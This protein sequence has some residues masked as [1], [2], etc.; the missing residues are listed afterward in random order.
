[1][2]LT[3]RKKVL[4]QPPGFLYICTSEALFYVNMDLIFHTCVI[5][6]WF[7]S[8]SPDQKGC[9]PLPGWRTRVCFSPSLEWRGRCSNCT[10]CHNLAW[11]SCIRTQK[12]ATVY[13]LI[14]LTPCL[15]ISPPS[16]ERGIRLMS[17]VT[18]RW[19]R[20]TML[21]MIRFDVPDLFCSK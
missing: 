18:D 1:M 12:Q 11:W 4:K 3:Y 20:V 6:L 16:G 7:D 2:H 21:F 5:V 9:E 19:V 10:C 15:D 17:F 13:L 8:S 14:Y